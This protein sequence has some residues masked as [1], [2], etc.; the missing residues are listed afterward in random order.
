M[1]VEWIKSSFTVAGGTTRQ[2]S[3]RRIITLKETGR[4]SKLRS[5]QMLMISRDRFLFQQRRWSW[6]PWRRVQQSFWNWCLR[7]VPPHTSCLTC[8]HV[9]R[10]TC[11]PERQVYGSYWAVAGNR[12]AAPEQSGIEWFSQK[13]LSSAA[14]GWLDKQQTFNVAQI[15]Q[16]ITINL[17]FAVEV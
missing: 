2:A 15:S 8:W 5:D 6:L 12:T 4:A 7:M 3:N 10:D 13:T 14:W 1:E 11:G 9:A 16:E 17:S